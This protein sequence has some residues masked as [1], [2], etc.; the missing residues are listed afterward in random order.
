M[1]ITFLCLTVLDYNDASS[2][3]ETFL[4]AINRK[5]ISCGEKFYHL[6]N[7]FKYRWNKPYLRKRVLDWNLYASL[8][9][10]MFITLTRTNRPEPYAS[11]PGQNP[12][13]DVSVATW[14]NAM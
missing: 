1:S 7:S 13:T 6:P 14:P 2:C 10:I 12:C 5:I 3:I 9:V 4:L 8:V 11:S